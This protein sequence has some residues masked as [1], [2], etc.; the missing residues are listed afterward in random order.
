MKSP[1]TG[2]EMSIYKEWRTM[3]YRKEEF[4]V[5]FHV[6]K[7]E[8][9]GQQFEDETFANLNYIQLVNQYRAKYT[10]PFPEQI[11][12]IREKYGLSASKMSEVLGFG[13]NSYRNYEAGEVPNQ[14]NRV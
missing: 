3:S 1:F 6:Y 5:Y 12:S 13:A 2:K 10:I 11:K 4:K 9:T 7:C 14:S 8:D